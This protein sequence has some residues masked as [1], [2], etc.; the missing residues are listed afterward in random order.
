MRLAVVFSRSEVGH[1]DARLARRVN[2]LTAAQGGSLDRPN[3][4]QEWS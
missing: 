4:Y 3:P 1:Y 2:V